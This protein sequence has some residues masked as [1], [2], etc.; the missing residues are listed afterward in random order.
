M[1]SPF[2]ASAIREALLEDPFS[3]FGGVQRF[4]IRTDAGVYSFN[5]MQTRSHNA[6]I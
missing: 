6:R 2:T 5:V 4:G 1:I 3:E